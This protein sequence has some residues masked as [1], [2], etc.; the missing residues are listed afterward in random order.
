[1]LFAER[2]LDCGIYAILQPM[3]IRFALDIVDDVV[4]MLAS[5]SKT[6]I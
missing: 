5:C 1:V 6:E 2:G 4:L 3:L